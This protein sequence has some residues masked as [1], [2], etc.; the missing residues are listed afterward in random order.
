MKEMMQ[1]ISMEDFNY[2]L[3]RDRIAEYPVKERDQSR[4]LIMGEGD[5]DDDKF[6]N[7]SSYLPSDGLIVFNNTRVIRARLLFYKE[8]G[9]R[10]EVFCLEPVLPTAEIS[11]A[12]EQKSG[13]TWKCL[14]GNARKWREGK[15]LLKL[16]ID[17]EEVVLAV[18]RVGEEDGAFLVR[19][20]WDPPEVS[21][22]GIIESAGKI[23]LPPYIE[24]EA[25]D[26][27]TYRYQTIYAIHD[28]SVAAPTAGLHFT[29][30]VMQSLSKK[31]IEFGNVTLH[32]G[33]GTFKPVSDSDIRDHE[34]HTEQIIISRT[35]IEAILSNKA[36]L[37]AVGT[38]SVRSLES[39]YWYGVTLETDPNAVF[40]I[41]QWQPYQPDKGI[42]A[43]RSLRNI[44]S[45]MDRDSIDFISGDTSLIIVPGYK[46]HLI[47]IMITNFHMP[48]STL[49]LLVAAFT[50]NRWN[51]AY[52]YALENDFRFLSYGDS[53]LFFRKD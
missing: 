30:K 24:R 29:D 17:G 23:P 4:L 51:E 19:F 37:T 32:V 15:L 10:I 26:E 22:A 1:H 38:T 39:L 16:E 11:S 2:D 50:A 5:I 27:D 52:K 53:C 36:K 21:F 44:L 6:Y 13:V 49:L 40:S 48:K 7:L 31:N 45:R 12:F 8:T 33:A 43:E 35:L 28:G 46:F 9:A 34:M 42:S 47:D 18:E 14:I 41:K 20:S 25:D 3:P